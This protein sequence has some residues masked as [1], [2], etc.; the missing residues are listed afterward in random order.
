M[1]CKVK[2]IWPF[3]KT[4]EDTN[5]TLFCRKERYKKSKQSN[6]SIRNWILTTIK[7]EQRQQQEQLSQLSYESTLAV[8]QATIQQIYVVLYIDL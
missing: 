4:E 7:I 2:K 6:S 5:I 8:I 3:I 1:L